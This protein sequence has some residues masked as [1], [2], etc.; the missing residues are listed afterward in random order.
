MADDNLIPQQ[1]K[2]WWFIKLKPRDKV[3]I[4]PDWPNRTYAWDDPELLKWIEQG[5]N[6][7]VIGDGSHVIIDGDTAEVQEAVEKFL[8]ET[9]TVRTPGHLG[10]HYYFNASIENPIRLRD[11][12]G[13]NVGDVQGKGKQVVG[14]GCI[15]PVGKP[16]EIVK[17]VPPVSVSEEQIREA[18][19]EFIAP[20]PEAMDWE[21]QERES[22]ISILAV[23]SLNGMRRQG[24]EFYGSHPVHGSETGK[25]FWINPK[26]NVWHCFRHSSGGG[27]LSLLAVKEGII[28]CEE[29]RPGALRGAVFKRVLKAARETGIELKQALKE[30]KGEKEFIPA[31]VARSVQSK[32]RFATHKQSHE[33]WVYKNG[34]YYP[35]G[36]EV[37][38]AEVREL[39]GDDAT[40]HR[41]G[42]V[43]SHIR[44]TTFTDP[45]KFNP[46]LE[47]INLENGVLNLKTAE[48]EK[49]AL[50]VIFTNK[51]PVKYDPRARCPVI[52]KFLSEILHPDDI[53]VIQEF[54]GYCLYRKYCFA[55]ALMC[56]G[57]GSNGKSTLLMLIETLLGKDN[58]ATPSLQRLLY[59]RFA[60]AELFGK[61]A[62][63]HA[64]LPPTPLAQ[65]GMFKMLTGGDTIHAERKHQDPFNFTNYAKLIYSANELPQTADLTEAFWRRW[66]I[67]EFP[68][69]FPEGDPKTDPHVLKKLTTPD[70]LSGFLN[71]ALEGLK[72][73]LE[74][75]KFTPTKTRAEI[76]EEWTIRTDSLRAFVRKHAAVD[77][78]CFVT[79]GDFY[80]AYQD[81]CSEHEAEA[82]S[83]NMVGLRLP[84][85]MRC[86]GQVRKIGGEAVRVWRGI[87][88]TG[89]FEHKENE[90]T[91]SQVLPF[92]LFQENDHSKKPLIRK[93]LTVVTSVA[94]QTPTVSDLE[95]RLFEA[96]GVNPFKPSQLPKHFSDAELAKLSAV[97]D[98]MLKRGK[99]MVVFTESGE[100][101]FQLVRK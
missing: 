35:D 6:Y 27:P 77:P 23:H 71:W 64:D 92:L 43:V 4:E 83:K 34:V 52:L 57:A 78:R 60:A 79:K 82:V 38:R 101:A 96:F 91:E 36:E 51:L 61:L 72:R 30:A 75:S 100:Q 42:E 19:A 31:E 74:N 67:V 87:R 56:V 66:I 94:G 55:R 93:P 3:P 33:V 95:H 84:T 54:V 41:V 5:G 99:L 65:T 69:A 88:L 59:N 73:L 53:P 8:P 28:K 10:K 14:P 80:A 47:R 16:Y 48:L 76:E 22:G 81:F 85:I 68:N 70:E 2:D 7:G 97:M 15:H 25:N 49:H 29:A 1:L 98:E 45:E 40:D 24:N 18:L 12:N 9:F 86:S 11:K 13:K 58:V 21:Q 89:K 62:N 50:D 32:Y 90:V 37:I 20:E 63:I 46:P 44:D 26:Q 39:L 17:D